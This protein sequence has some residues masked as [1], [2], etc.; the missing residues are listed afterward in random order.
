ME[1]LNVYECRDMLNDAL[2]EMVTAYKQEGMEI[3]VGRWDLRNGILEAGALTATEFRHPGSDFS[4]LFPLCALR[5]S[6]G[7]FPPPS[8]F[9][10][11]I[12]NS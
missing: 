1:G 11:S 2:R 10:L 8:H 6:V 12:L 5:A 9:R 4:L 7:K 3:P